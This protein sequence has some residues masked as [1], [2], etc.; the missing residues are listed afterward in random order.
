MILHVLFTPD[1]I[2]GW[3]GTR[4]R[5]GSEEV[6]LPDDL[7]NPVMFLAARR[8]D[9]DGDWVMR[10]PPPPPTAEEL[11]ALQ[12]EADQAAAEAAAEADRLREEEVARRTLPFTLQRAVGEITIAELKAHR[13]R[14]RAEI[15]AGG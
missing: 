10:D 2:P 8:R 9:A 3:I 6:D 14:I 11:A 15:E 12:A 7:A 4:S 5:E 1:G 13:A